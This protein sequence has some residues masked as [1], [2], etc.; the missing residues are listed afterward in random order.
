MSSLSNLHAYVF[1]DHPGGNLRPLTENTCPA[2]LSVVGKPVILHALEGLCEARARRA[3]LVLSAFADEVNRVLG[4]GRRWGLELGYTLSQG[5]ECMHGLE[6][7]LPVADGPHLLV[8]GDV[9]HSRILV[10]FLDQIDAAADTAYAC[11]GDTV[12]ACFCRQQ[13]TLEALRQLN[14]PS[15]HPAHTIHFADAAYSALASLAAFHRVNL[16]ILAGRFPG[17]DPAGREIALGLIRGRHARVS[18]R[19]LKQG[20]AFV[21]EAS[22][23]HPQAEFAGEVVLAP[24]VIVD[25]EAAIRDSVILPDTYIGELV[26]IHDAI[27]MG[28]ILIRV[29]NGAITR[30]SDS[31]LLAD[32]RATRLHTAVA[33]FLNRGLGVGLLLLS[34]PLWAWVRLRGY[35][36]TG[37]TQALVGN[38]LEFNPAGMRQRRVFETREFACSS[39]LLRHLPR[40]WAVISGDLRLIGVTPLTPQQASK[41]REAWEK[42]RDSAPVGLIGPSQL[43]LSADAP[44]E[45]KL[46][47]DAYYAQK[48][49]TR[50]DLEYLWLGLKQ[51]FRASS[52]R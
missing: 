47:C 22:R 36:G 12:V 39:P 31:F 43:L 20:S 21:G 4:D 40:L 24:R 19:S 41:R 15:E 49:G 28:N 6:P 52:W 14:R 29:D 33:D 45:E 42:V 38:R 13:P 2:L 16:D 23:V 32:L 35:A 27:V 11:I 37:Q 9:L 25:K 7:R 51:L 50:K 1:A 34:L 26:E 46:L 44:L 48:R 17:I 18:P 3:T 5:E 8:R 30:I 10:S